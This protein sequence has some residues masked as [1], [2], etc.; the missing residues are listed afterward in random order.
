MVFFFELKAGL[1]VFGEVGVE[2]FGALDGAA[3]VGD[4]F[5]EG[6]K[7]TIVHVGAGEYEIPE[8]WGGKISAEAVV[9]QL[10]VGEVGAAVAVEAIGSVLLA[11]GFVFGKE[12]FHAAFFGGSEF[13]FAG[14][15][16]V[17]F[18]IVASEGEEEIFEGEGDFFF[19]D[20][21]WAEGFLEG[22]AF[23]LFEMSNHAGE[24]GGH[25]FVILNGLED[26]VAEGLGAAIPEEGGFPG[27]VEEGHG[28]TVTYEVIDAFGEGDAVGEGFVFM[29]ASG[30]GDG[31][32]FREGFVV[33]ERFAKRDAF[34]EE[35]VVAGEE[36]HGEAPAHLEREGGVCFGKEKGG[37]GCEGDF[38]G[39]VRCSPY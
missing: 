22:G 17:E 11:A 33:E 1:G 4:D 16:A 6:L 28:V 30:A 20:F 18:G 29:V 13:G 36:G 38:F 15:G 24:V 23:G 21:S 12:E 10:V 26:L 27:E 7:A 37:D 14:H 5:F 9:V 19:G 34:Y 31:V 25:F 32:V 2:V 8:T 39:R 3:V 35:G